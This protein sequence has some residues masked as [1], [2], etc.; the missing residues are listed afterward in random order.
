MRKDASDIARL[1][2]I[3]AW[4]WIGYL[5]AL[6][7]IDQYMYAGAPRNMLGRY[8][9]SN[10]VAALI[11]LG[12]SYAAPIQKA[13]K[14]AYVALML[15]II[16]AW[17]IVTSRVFMP[18][19]P[20]GPMS[21]IEG[22]TLRMLPILFIA[23]VITAWQ[24]P[25]PYVVLFAVGTAALEIGIIQIKPP[26]QPSAFHAVVFI[27]IVR[28]VSFLV[29]GYFISRL[30]QR[31]QAQQEALAQANAQ[32]THYASTLENLTVS[33]E[34]NRM[35]RELH[36]TLAHTLSGLAV[37]LETLKA[38]WEVDPQAAH[39]LLDQSL[40]AT[41]SGLGETRRALKALRASPLEDLGL[42]LGIRKLAE[43]AAERGKLAL[44]LE[45]PGQLPA[46]APDVEQC[47]Y[48]VA[49][50]AVENVVHHANATHL[51]VRL[52]ASETELRLTIQ[53][54]GQG[55]NVEQARR[56]GHFGLPGMYERAQLAG[57]ELRI[58]SQ[59]G[60]GTRLQLAIKG[61]TH[62]SDHL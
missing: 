22:I 60:N 59:P 41:R 14:S 8:Y 32:L 44:E 54:D 47:I 5:L 29:V 10:G 33:R 36:D 37:Q 35:A 34:R 31:L 26:A 62:E 21:N 24:Y 1:L 28:S 12:L 2:Q 51:A 25:W 57:G 17:P 23:L 16:S 9:L 18:P 46:V 19:L 52:A 55:L 43:T 27:A 6:V 39:K 11:F 56:A 48:R 15:L 7:A 58:D 13:L 4:M 45:L 50:E 20:P 49:Q 40:E 61:H 42:A 30:M 38:Y 3:A 53:D